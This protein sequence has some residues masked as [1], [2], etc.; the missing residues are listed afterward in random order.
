MWGGF[1]RHDDITTIVDILAVKTFA[2]LKD[3]D[4][5]T[6]FTLSALIYKDE[7]SKSK[8][9]VSKWMQRFLEIYTFVAIAKH[10]NT[11][12]DIFD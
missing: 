12:I 2:S 5:C 4:I 1:L 3:L 8:F 6:K 11:H 10:I 9:H 7:E